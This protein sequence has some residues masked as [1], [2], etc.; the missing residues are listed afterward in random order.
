MVAEL[1]ECRLRA[2]P[3]RPKAPAGHGGAGAGHAGEEEP[4]WREAL[5]ASAE[6]LRSLLTSSI[7]SR[8]RKGH[9]FPFIFLEQFQVAVKNRVVSREISHPPPISPRTASPTVNTRYQ[10]GSFV[11]TPGPAQMRHYHPESTVTFGFPPGRVRAVG[12]TDG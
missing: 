3:G 10:S 4:S 6:R 8:A 9:F 1:W 7:S 11:T 12:S 5:S 2:A